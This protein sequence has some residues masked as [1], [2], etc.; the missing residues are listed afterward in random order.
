MQNSTTINCKVCYDNQIRRFTFVGT[1]FSS[2]KKQ[3]LNL[4]NLQGEFVLKYLD[5]ESDLITITSNEDLAL[6]LEYSDK[7]LRLTIVTDTPVVSSS[8]P[9]TPNMPAPF[10]P[11]FSHRNDHHHHPGHNHHGR[12]KRGSCGRGGPHTDKWQG[13][14]IHLIMK[15]DSLKSF[16]AQFPEESQLTPRQ[17]ARKQQVATKI[18]HLENHLA[19]WDMRK[20]MKCNKHEEKLRQRSERC[21]RKKNLSP[22]TMEQIRVLKEQIKELKAVK[23]QIKCDMYRR[24]CLLEETPDSS[25]ATW[26]EIQNLQPKFNAVK[27]QI[28]PLKQ[29]IRELKFGQA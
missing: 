4:F 24:K 27:S 20:E 23:K 14:K 9:T 25:A 6:A 17:L 26:E 7:L 28:W 16:H 13:K 21:G 12:G 19:Q 15:L 10:E 29:K 5:N 18:Q 3:V 2:L 22:E 8:I 1:E 11:H